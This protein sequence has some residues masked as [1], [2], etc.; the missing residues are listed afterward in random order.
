MEIERVVRAHARLLY[1]VAYGIVRCPS[2]AEDVCQDAVVKLLELPQQLRDAQAV[3]AWLVRTVA[4][5]ALLH[6]RRAKTQARVFDRLGRSTPETPQGADYL[7]REKLLDGL[8]SL[9]EELREVVVLRVVEGLSGVEVQRVLG[10]SAAD[11][12][13][14]L[15]AGL[16]RLR[17][18]LRSRPG[19]AEE[20]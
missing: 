18:H 9:E 1:R 2:V 17:L 20:R 12:S 16:N 5:N 13:R 8:A 19:V 7:L 6:L 3:R 10:L 14:R 15:H 4:N 11:V